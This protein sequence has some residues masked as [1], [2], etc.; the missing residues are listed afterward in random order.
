MATVSFTSELRV[1]L[2]SCLGEYFIINNL[3]RSSI[4]F[5]FGMLMSAAQ[6]QLEDLHTRG[7]VGIIYS[8]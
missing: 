7:V 1:K 5:A 2:D 4:V 3:L 6:K 8:L